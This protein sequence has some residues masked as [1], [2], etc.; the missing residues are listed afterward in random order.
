MT[1]QSAV[2]SSE[3]ALR[4]KEAL[5][6]RKG[7]WPLAGRRGGLKGIQ[8]WRKCRV[9][10]WRRS[11]RFKVFFAPSFA[12]WLSHA[13]HGSYRPSQP[14]HLH[15]LSLWKCWWRWA[16]SSSPIGTSRWRSSH[17]EGRARFQSLLCRSRLCWLQVIE[18]YLAPFF[19]SSSRTQF[20]P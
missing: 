3:A 8:G 12:Y 15:R 6:R 7:R 5:G 10:L 14:D 18:H 13:Q 2:S 4:S 17:E 20:G 1:P 19:S 9:G 16:G 11:C